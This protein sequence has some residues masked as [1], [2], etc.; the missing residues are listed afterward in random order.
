PIVRL[1]DAATGR[2][3]RNF[4]GHSEGVFALSFSPD[5]KRLATAAIDST[6]R[7][8]DVA[9]GASIS[10]FAKHKEHVFAVDWSPDGQLVATGGSDRMLRIWDAGTGNERLSVQA[11]S[12]PGIGSISGVAWS[13]D[14]LRVAL[15]LTKPENAVLV[16]D[17]S[18]GRTLLTL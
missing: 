5:G 10:T 1:W 6:A 2:L 12:D 11:T 7:I 3:I 9:T 14:G 17:A 4:K 8:W 13:P 18:T 15:A 16:L